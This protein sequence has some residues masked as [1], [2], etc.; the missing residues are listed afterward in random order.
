MMGYT[1]NGSSGT[2]PPD[3]TNGYPQGYSINLG[4]GS[5]STGTNPLFTYDIVGHEF[6]HAVDKFS[7]NIAASNSY[8][9]EERFIL[10]EGMC[11]IMGITIESKY[12][13]ND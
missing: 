5:P 11:D 2:I 13:Q 1:N 3:T 7:V 12:K 8:D 9:F 4:L 6:M 10:Y